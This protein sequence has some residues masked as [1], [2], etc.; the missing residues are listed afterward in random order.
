MDFKI[1]FAIVMALLIIAIP[2]VIVRGKLR[3]AEKPASS[4]ASLSLLIPSGVS[5]TFSAI[6]PLLSLEPRINGM[7]SDGLITLRI[8]D[9]YHETD[10]SDWSVVKK[11]VDGV[12]MKATE[13]TTYTD[14]A[15]KTYAQKAH[16]QKIP[17]GFYHYFWPAA[18]IGSAGKQADYFYQ[19]IRGIPYDFYPVL[20]IEETNGQNAQTVCKNA[21]AFCDEFKKLSG[22]NVMIYCSPAFAN[23]NLADKSFAAQPL[24]IANYKVN[25]PGLTTVWTTFDVWQFGVDVTVPGIRGEVDGN[26]ATN[27]IY[28]NPK[29]APKL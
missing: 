19:S 12:Y 23:R 5:H 6:M 29:S 9:I 16:A 13:G 24:W 7:R 1:I 17:I 25:D 2:C 3:P 14:P 18:D 28:L 21:R 8:I 10:V 22:K 20:D 15:F 26:I 11:N 27:N 4:A